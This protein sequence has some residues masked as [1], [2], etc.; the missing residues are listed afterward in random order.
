MRGKLIAGLV[1]GLVI[2]GMACFAGAGTMTFYVLEDC[3]LA[4]GSSANSPQNDSALM[5]GNEAGSDREGL[6]KFDVSQILNDQP[7]N[8][9][10]IIGSMTFGAYNYSNVDNGSTTSTSDSVNIALGNTDNWTELAAT[11]TSNHGDYASPPIT[12]TVIGPSNMNGYVYWS[13]NPS[14][15]ELDTI[16][17]NYLISFY[18]Y[19]VEG[20]DDLNIFYQQVAGSNYR[21]NLTIDVQYVP[22]PTWD[23]GSDL[24]EVPEPST[25]LLFCSGL[26]FLAGTKIRRKRQ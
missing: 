12:S 8:Q 1:V 4:S 24:P 26:A 19:P 18:L 15:M 16:F 2:F 9:I 17:D 3:Y 7:D 21:A 11:W 23:P 10:P 20:N 14:N 6:L 22:D 5:V 13:W 25:I